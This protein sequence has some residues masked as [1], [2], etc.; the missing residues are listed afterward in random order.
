MVGMGEALATFWG[1]T[2][3]GF[4][5]VSEQFRNLIQPVLIH[6]TA[7]QLLSVGFLHSKS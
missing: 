3:K 1:W 2:V 5:V 7:Y 4:D 6:S